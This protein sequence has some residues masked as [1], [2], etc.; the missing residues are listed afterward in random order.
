MSTAMRRLIFIFLAVTGVF[1]GGELSAQNRPVVPLRKSPVD[2][3]RELLALAP[4]ERAKALAV[5]PDHFRK[6]IEAKIAEYE[7]LP[8]EERELRLRTTQLRWHLLPLMRMPPAARAAR[9]A[10]IPAS[11]RAIV[12]SRL[13]AWDKFPADLQRDVLA[14]ESALLYLLRADARPPMPPPLAEKAPRDS[15]LRPERELAVWHQLPAARR[16]LMLEQFGQFFELDEVEKAKTLGALSAVERQ[17]MEKTLR[18]FEQLP[19][20]QR[21]MCLRSFRLFANMS[22]E[23]QS[24]FL[25]NAERWKAM[26]P[27]ERQTWREL[28][29]QLPPMPPGL[30]DP[31][32]PANLAPLTQTTNRYRP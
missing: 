28:V 17:D 12:E 25:K 20:P 6:T 16:Q 29:S 2:T 7:T 8:A 4:A 11:E 1:V 10:A 32:M 13:L 30:G 24:G 15:V 22:A 14:N 26:K 27:E 9:L 5:H 23:E 21:V 18:D 31:L 19:Q 3:F